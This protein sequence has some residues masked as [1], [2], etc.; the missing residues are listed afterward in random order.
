MRQRE[1]GST[2]LTVKVIGLGAMPLSIQGRPDEAG[3]FEVIEAFVA[4]GGDFI[5]T[6]NVYCLADSDI[7]HN[8]RPIRRVLDRPGASDRVVV[9]KG[10]PRRSC[11]QSLKALETRRARDEEQPA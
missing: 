2:G 10:G 1:L 11:E 7:G 9:A 4:G 5:E 3:A 8:E 6:T